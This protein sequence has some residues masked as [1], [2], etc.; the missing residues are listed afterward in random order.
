MDCVG[1]T[2]QLSPFLPYFSFLGHYVTC[3]FSG[4]TPRR[5]PSAA[6]WRTFVG[7]KHYW[8]LGFYVVCCIYSDVFYPFPFVPLLCLYNFHYTQFPQTNIPA[9]SINKIGH[10]ILFKCTKW[11]IELN[12]DLF[13]FFFLIKQINA[14]S[15]YI[16]HLNFNWIFGSLFVRNKW[17][18]PLAKNA[19]CSQ[20]Y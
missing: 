18:W 6:I 16:D 17:Y 4:G 9:K 19:D 20:I 5:H 12:I 3:R 1:E 15:V 10:F 11:T 2:R 14:V 7:D 13:F 8:P